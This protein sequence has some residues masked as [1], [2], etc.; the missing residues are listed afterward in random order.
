[1]PERFERAAARA[2]A[3]NELT[4]I[5]VRRRCLLAAAK[6]DE[7]QA[8]SSELENANGNG[9]RR[10]VSR[11]SR[12]PSASPHCDRAPLNVVIAGLGGQGVLTAS[13]ILAEAALLAGFDVK[14][15]DVHGM[16]QRG[17][18]VA[19]DV[20]F[21]PRCSARWFRRARP[22]SWWCWPKTGGQQPAAACG[23]AA[24]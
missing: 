15:A 8:G 22:I 11:E 1:M 2:L 21:G 20:R 17:G 9:C 4:V 13:D 24:C 10:A 18:S 5:V 7:R 14:K 16:S 3:G 6:Q 12:R 23:Q 19:S